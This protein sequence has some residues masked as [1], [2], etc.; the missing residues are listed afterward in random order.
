M[1]AGELKLARDQ[2]AAKATLLAKAMMDQV[3]ARKGLDTLAK[4]VQQA[5]DVYNRDDQSAWVEISKARVSSE[6]Y[7]TLKKDLIFIT[8]QRN[9]ASR[10]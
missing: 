6:R 8:Q 1:E 5:T 7:E 3:K 10:V 2:I 9:E 4:E